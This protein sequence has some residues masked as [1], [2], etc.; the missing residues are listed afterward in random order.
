MKKVFSF[1]ILVLL[2]A[3]RGSA[4]PG[5]TL[6]GVI[7]GADGTPFRAAFVRAQNVKTKMNVMVLTDKKG[8]YWAAGLPPGTYEVT[9]TA[10]GFKSDPPRVSDVKVEDGKTASAGFKMQKSMIQWSQ[11]TKYQAGILLPAGPERDVVI[12]DCDNCHHLSKI[13]AVGRHD[14]DGWIQDI[15]FMRQTGVAN[16]DDDTKG[17]NPGIAEKAATYLES[18]F[19]PDSTTPMSPAQLPDYQKVKQEGDYF[20]DDT[21]SIEYVDY[22]LF[23]DPKDRPGAAQPDKDG[24]IW[25]E[26]AG[27]VAK[28]NPATA[29]VQGFH[30]PGRPR[31]IHD[32][33]PKA[34]GSVWITVEGE[35]GLAR[36]DTQTGKFD[37][38]YVDKDLTAKF[39]TPDM[40]PIQAEATSPFPNLAHPDNTGTGGPRAHTPMVDHQGNIWV[41]G[42]PLKRYDPETKKWTFFA[43]APDT[44]GID[45]D[46]KGNVWFA[47]F[48]AKD[49]RNIGMV[50]VKTDKVT[51]YQPPAGVTPR[52]LKVDSKGKVWFADY[53]GAVWFD[54]IPTP[55]TLR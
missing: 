53:F 12:H 47:E 8:Q 50:D 55:K 54:L 39:N 52:R 25:F 9:A 32:I 37:P 16:L 42:R 38:L 13:G 51:I 15:D 35:N 1:V 18:V 19:G 41:T 36:L 24:N 46:Q 40:R 44:Y 43:D 14:H 6:S 27:G 29:E 33:T 26:L 31:F 5:G 20:A 30:L 3:S 2:F 11:L 10:I 17:I 23:G 21:L 7:M 4:A 49:H 45:V 34:E 22:Q 48:N 28:L